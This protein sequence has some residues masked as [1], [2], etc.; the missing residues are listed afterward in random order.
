MSTTTIGTTTHREA[1]R[2]AFRALRAQGYKARM[3]F[4]CCSSCGWA[5]LSGDDDQEVALVFWNRQADG[6]FDE[7]GD[8]RDGSLHLQWSGD[9]G[10]ILAALRT[11]GLD[12]AWAGSEY[13][14]IE[15]KD[16]PV[17]DDGGDE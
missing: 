8:L 10:V 2:A 4:A 3:N 16:T 11:Q 13:D 5:E 6:A 12:A 15:V 9:A 14:A 1:L 17:S 7:Y